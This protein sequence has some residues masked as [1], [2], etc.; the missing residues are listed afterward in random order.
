MGSHTSILIS[1]SLDGLRVA[2]TRQNAG[3]S[4]KALLVV[5]VSAP[6][7]CADVIEVFGKASWR[8]PVQD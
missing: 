4:G 8:R 3:R 2:A 7:T 5:N 1:E 6:A